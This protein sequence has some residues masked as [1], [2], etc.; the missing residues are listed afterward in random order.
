MVK[1][2]DFAWKVIN[3]RSILYCTLHLKLIAANRYFQY[4]E[5]I[6]ER[7]IKLRAALINR[8]I[9]MLLRDIV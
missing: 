5:L 4:S 7:L 6:Y 3:V 1:Y 2:D 8:N 9:S